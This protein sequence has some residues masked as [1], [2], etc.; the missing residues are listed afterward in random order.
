MEKEAGMKERI[1]EALKQTGNHRTNAAKLLG[2]GKST[3][4]NRMK[5]FGLI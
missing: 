2:I 3:L 1:I 4:Y 5:S